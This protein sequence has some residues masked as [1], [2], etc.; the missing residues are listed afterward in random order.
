MII[1][2]KMVSMHAQQGEIIFTDFEPD[3]GIAAMTPTDNGDTIRLDIDHDGTVDF[4][5]YIG[6][7]NST[8]IRYVFVSSP[9]YFRFCYNSQ[10]SYG[11]LDEN[12][13]LV[14]EPHA[15]GTW[16]TPNS[17]WALLWEPDNTDY[18]EFLMGFRKVDND[19]NYYAWSR[20]YMTRN[21][22]GIRHHAQHGDFDEVRA[23][24]DN[25]SYCTIPNYPL[26]WGQTSMD[27]NLL[28]EAS[29]VP[30]ASIHPNPID[31]GQLT[32]LGNDLR[33][34]VV[35]NTLGQQVARAQGEGGAMH[36]DLSG[37][38]TGIYLVS[39]TDNEGRRCVRKAVKQ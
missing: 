29:L 31:G 8:M 6:Y 32:V 36:I 12:D 27:W 14:S 22:N 18:M 5:M 16:G 15:P 23:Y 33:E 3:L 28:E 19:E 9:W 17:S 2:I 34:A 10:Y 7:L 21:H 11:Y 38:P 24:C 26:R 25:L 35:F 4:N 37:Q 13:T 39:V 30:F 1:L 20:I